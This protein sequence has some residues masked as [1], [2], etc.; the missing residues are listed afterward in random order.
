MP[1][2]GTVAKGVTFTQEGTSIRFKWEG[3]SAL[4]QIKAGETP[5]SCWQKLASA[6][7]GEQP[8]RGA[9]SNGRRKRKGR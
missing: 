9:R 8:R 4:T 1:T 2:T 6:M 7:A 5:Q 3:G